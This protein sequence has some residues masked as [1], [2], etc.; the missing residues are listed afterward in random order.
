MQ[1]LTTY[2]LYYRA[3]SKGIKYKRGESNLFKRHSYFQLINA[4]KGLFVSSVYS[5]DQIENQIMS[6]S[7]KHKYYAQ[8]YKINKYSNDKDLFIKVCKSISRRYNL[9][10]DTNYPKRLINSI[11]YSHHVYDLNAHLEDFQRMY[12]FEHDLRGVLLKHVLKI[13]ETMKNIFCNSLNDLKKQSNYL[14]DINN[15][16]LQGYKVFE[17][18]KTVLSKNENKHSKPIRR[19]NEQELIPPFWILINELTLNQA[20]QTIKRLKASESDIISEKLTI[21]LTNLKSPTKEQVKSY[22]LLLDNIGIF[23]NMLAH[24]QPIF[25]FNVD[26]CDLNNY[27]N[28][29]YTLPKVEKKKQAA[30]VMK[31]M[32][33]LQLFYG[34]DH[35]NVKLYDS[36]LDLSNIIYLIN[37]I[38]NRINPISNFSDE[39]RTLYS[40]YNIYQCVDIVNVINGK[41]TLDAM[42]KLE[43]IYM[44]LNNINF[45]EILQSN[46][47]EKEIKKIL[48]LKNANLLE[49]KKIFKYTLSKIKI[50]KYR[51]KYKQFLFTKRYEE[52]TGI[53]IN[54][55]RQ[56]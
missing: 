18:I 54:F 25:D 46:S 53:N 4:Y 9:K 16:N 37:K 8:V 15:Y 45:K 28:I 31:V 43:E 11:K 39:I 29:S 12:E 21:E 27:P 3:R 23:R 20:L 55:L 1:A 32:N 41:E 42:Q 33:D 50:E 2:E 14:L 51:S 19:K 56:L 44:N 35:Y 26:D 48:R 49:T 38:V 30:A 13:E 5:I 17:T 40:K 36:N 47:T 52:Y 22:I 10:F 7:G 6:D 24:N 34:K